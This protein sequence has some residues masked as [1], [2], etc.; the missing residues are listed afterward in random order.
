MTVNS[1][2][3]IYPEPGS[4]IVVPRGLDGDRGAVVL[5]ATHRASDMAIH[6]DIDGTYHGTTTGD[7]RLATAL[8]PGQHRLTLTDTDGERTTVTFQV[9]HAAEAH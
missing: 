9:M 4:R 5:H 2:E 6:W 8:A 1:M 3:V 7:H